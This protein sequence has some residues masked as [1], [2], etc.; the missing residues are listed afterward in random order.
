MASD[1]VPGAAQ[2]TM[3][4]PLWG[5]AHGGILSLNWDIGD[6]GSHYSGIP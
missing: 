1:I 6:I 4:G 2:Q 3:A 5:N